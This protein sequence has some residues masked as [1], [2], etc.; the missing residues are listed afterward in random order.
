MQHAGVNS[1]EFL[2]TTQV[3]QILKVSAETVRAWER[4]GRLPAIRTA[5]GV[6]LFSREDVERLALERGPAPTE[7]PSDS[8]PRRVVS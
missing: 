7:Q 8:E 6:R 3:A 2:F 4:R 1:D 5:I